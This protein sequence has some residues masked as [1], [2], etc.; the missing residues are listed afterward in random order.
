MVSSIPRLGLDLNLNAASFVG[1]AISQEQDLASLQELF[2]PEGVHVS[3]PS[4]SE[5]VRIYSIFSQF[6]A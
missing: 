6:P 5:D 1:F 3:P 4:L 2:N